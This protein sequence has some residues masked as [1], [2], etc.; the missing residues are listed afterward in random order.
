MRAAGHLALL[1]RRLRYGAAMLF[2]SLVALSLSAVV[3]AGCGGDDEPRDSASTPVAPAAQQSGQVPE[4]SPADAKKKPAG[5]TPEWVDDVNARCK[6]HE[7]ATNKVLKEFQ[8]NG[9]SGPESA[10]EAMEE[11]VP[12]GRKLIADLREAEVPA[13]VK[14]R[15]IA[16]L[17]SLDGAF[18]LIP[19]LTKTLTTGKENPELMK[20]LEKI[21]KD[22]RP[23]AD[24]YGLTGCLTSGG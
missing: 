19:Q 16:F 1:D 21:E 6:K 8:K 20:K 17:D 12:L 2:R 13:D 10:A 24:Q 18:D 22:T 5:P 23:F 9:V 14:V 3:L 11:V 7:A 4:D 15:W